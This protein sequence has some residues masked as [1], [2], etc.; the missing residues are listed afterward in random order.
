[1]NSRRC[2]VD[3]I[4]G[5]MYVHLYLSL[6]FF[7]RKKTL[8][9]L[10]GVCIMA[11]YQSRRI[12]N[13]NFFLFF[14]LIGLCLSTIASAET[15]YVHDTLIVD[16]RDRMG[17]SFK[18][19]TTVRT[20]DAVEVLE[21]SKHF[22]KVKTSK[23][24]VGYIAKQY[25]NSSLPK[26]TVISNL[27]GEVRKLTKKIALLQADKDDFSS[28]TQAITAQNE[29]YKQELSTTNSELDN[30]VKELERYAEKNQQLSDK[31]AALD[32]IVTERDNLQ[33]ELKKLHPRVNLLQERYNQAL[34]NTKE[35]AELISER[36]AIQ[37]RLLTVQSDFEFLQEKHQKF[38]DESQDMVS[39]I[40]ERDALLSKSKLNTQEIKELTDRTD[41]LEGT[42]MV[43][44]FLAGAGV[45]LIGL[46]IGKA[47]AR[48]KKRGGLSGVFILF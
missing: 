3:S 14:L 38:I 23:G 15:R 39:I 32:P 24:V 44:W 21:D 45:L 17:K 28:K 12:K 20:G 46:L 36:D 19:L 26:K 25:V 30:T 13:V 11:I 43:Y 48:S 22:V 10:I 41:E 16:V 31:I 18:V 42:Q 2:S 47:S 35:S 4:Y 37:D 9:I 27:Q 40:D 1:M 6:F 7:L 33:V 34:E 8:H 29:S 5:T